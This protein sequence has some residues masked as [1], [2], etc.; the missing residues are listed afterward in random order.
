MI[1]ALKTFPSVISHNLGNLLSDRL[2]TKEFTKTSSADGSRFK[3]A[4][5]K[6][7]LILVNKILIECFTQEECEQYLDTDFLEGDIPYYIFKKYCPKMVARILFFLRK[8]NVIK[9]EMHYS[10]LAFYFQQSKPTIAHHLL[11][12]EKRELALRIP[13]SYSSL[14][15]PRR[16]IS[17]TFKGSELIK[18][19]LYLVLGRTAVSD[20]DGGLS[21]S[22]NIKREKVIFPHDLDKQ[23]VVSRIYDVLIAK[24]AS[25]NAKEFKEECIIKWKIVWNNIKGGTKYRS[26]Y[27]SGPIFIYLFLRT[28]GINRAIIIGL[29]KM[30]EK[31]FRD[32]L[33]IMV[34]LY[35]EYRERDKRKSVC[36]YLLGIAEDIEE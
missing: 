28:K 15:E 19:I 7:G 29:C 11:L 8:N 10:D 5:T 21:V 17:L 14:N 3:I 13:I 31:D 33:K 25:L 36:A 23:S 26:P 20:I 1:N 12:L 34:P 24:E 22:F 2:V 6:Q 32:G 9:P 4:I 27:K 35:K 30:P 16:V 18:N